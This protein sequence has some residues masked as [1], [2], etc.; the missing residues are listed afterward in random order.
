MEHGILLTILKELAQ[1]RTLNR[2]TATNERQ[3]IYLVVL[4]FP[5]QSPDLW[6]SLRLNRLGDGFYLQWS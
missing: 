6:L 3:I 2:S 1:N 4:K 5:V